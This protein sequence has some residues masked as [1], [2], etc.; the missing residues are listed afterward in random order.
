MVGSLSKTYLKDVQ[1]S[2]G[3]WGGGTN[4]D[5]ADGIVD[6]LERSATNGSDLKEEERVIK[7]VQKACWGGCC[8]D[9]SDEGSDG[10][11]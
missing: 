9:S 3:V 10:S 2:L 7:R 1:R 4:R 11:Y 5:M 6:D 8:G